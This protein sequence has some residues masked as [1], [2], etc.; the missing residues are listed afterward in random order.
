MSLK[1]QVKGTADEFSG[2]AK[3]TAVKVTGDKQTEA[4]GKAENLAGKAEQ[5]FGSAKDKAAE[6][7]G[8][9]ADKAKSSL[10][11]GT[12]NVKDSE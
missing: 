1:D 7:T 12:D 10:D 3:E 11:E 4:K 2:K 8:T 9:I 6:L 5:A